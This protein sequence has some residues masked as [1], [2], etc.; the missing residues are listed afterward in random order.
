M[1]AGRLSIPNDNNKANVMPRI[2]LCKFFHKIR[3]EAIF[4]GLVLGYSGKFM[5]SRVKTIK[6]Y[7]DNGFRE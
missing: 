5:L 4:V 2:E 3:V 6:N 7:L 1:K